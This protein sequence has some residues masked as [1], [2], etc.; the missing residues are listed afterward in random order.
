VIESFPTL[1]KPGLHYGV[2][3]DTYAAWPAIS[4]SALSLAARSM[5]H[6]R[7]RKPVEETPQMRLGSLVHA[8]KFEPLLIPER[9][10][11]MP[12]FED[13]V[14]KPNGER[15]DNPK[16]SAAY[17][18]LVDEFTA[19]NVGKICVTRFEYETMLAM[20][21]ALA[22]HRGAT[23]WLTGGDYEVSIVAQDPETGLWCKGRIDHLHDP[24]CVSDLKTTSDLMR[25]GDAIF[26]W[27]YHRQL[28]LYG[29]MLDWLDV[30]HADPIE[31]R[32]IVAIDTEGPVHDI[33]AAPLSQRSITIGRHEF[34]RLLNQIATCEATGQW[35]GSD[36]PKE[37]ECPDR[38]LPDTMAILNGTLISL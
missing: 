37:W 5:A 24:R 26:N 13:Q 14:R 31:H 20:V 11:V 28:A 21:R 27:G 19:N 33:H 3:F 1:P 29:D 17:R 34:R 6:F 35:P 15:Y 10:V 8:G 4:N 9:Y 32:A 22:R 7:A 16:G 30:D 23:T 2:P 12:K 18:E 25:F 38:L 36:G